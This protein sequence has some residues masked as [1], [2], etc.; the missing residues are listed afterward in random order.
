MTLFTS[1]FTCPSCIGIKVVNAAEFILHWDA[2]HARTLGMIVVCDESNVSPSLATGLA[3]VSALKTVEVLQIDATGISLIVDEPVSNG[4]RHEGYA[5]ATSD[6]RGLANKV[7]LAQERAL[8]G[9]WRSEKEIREE[10]AARK[11]V[12]QGK[13]VTRPVKQRQ[14]AT[15]N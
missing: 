5:P 7:R 15:T 12:A 4:T 6:A 14:K 3:L 9:D 11:R 10:E 8:P 2:M 1:H 13:A